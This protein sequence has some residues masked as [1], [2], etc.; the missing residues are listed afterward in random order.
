M[1]RAWGSG[2]TA[3]QPLLQ[4]RSQS[5]KYGNNTRVAEP[6][7][8]VNTEMLAIIVSGVDYIFSWEN[9]LPLI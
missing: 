4:R 1:P 8:H 3:D 2:D 7:V 9:I 6:L 5:Y